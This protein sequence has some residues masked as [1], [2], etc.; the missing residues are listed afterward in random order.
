MGTVRE[1]GQDAAA[2]VI[3]PVR[4]TWPKSD[5][6]TA[7]DTRSEVDRERDATQL[8]RR[9]VLKTGGLRGWVGVGAAAVAGGPQQRPQPSA[10][11][12]RHQPWPEPRYGKWFRLTIIR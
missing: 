6:E 10:P 9:D 1:P 8:S 5:K 3:G 12:D 2:V 7:M 11:S 4:G